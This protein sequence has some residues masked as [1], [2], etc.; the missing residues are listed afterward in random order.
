MPKEV[1]I[2]IHPPIAGVGILYI[3]GGGTRGALPLRIIKRIYD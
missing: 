1:I 2:E 3:N